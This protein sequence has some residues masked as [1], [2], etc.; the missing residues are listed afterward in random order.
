MEEQKMHINA[1]ELLSD[2][3]A[4]RTLQ[5]SDSERQQDYQSIHK[6][7]GGANIELQL[8]KW[9]LDYQ[10]H[11]T[12]EYL[13]GVENKITDEESRVTKDCCNWMIHSQVFNQINMRWGPLEVDIFAS[14]LT[15]QTP[16]FFS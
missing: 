9:C 14:R 11:L 16:R 6:R 3:L 2:F 8:W 13:L 7:P 5:Y 12:A 4:I 15:H 10:V 1:L